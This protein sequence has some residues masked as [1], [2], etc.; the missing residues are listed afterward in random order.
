[1][2]SRDGEDAV[3]IVCIPGAGQ[4]PYA[5]AT[6]NNPPHPSF[7][8][9]HQTRHQTKRTRCDIQYEDGSHKL[10]WKTTATS[11]TDI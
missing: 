7:T 5:Y 8:P 2:Q 9:T 10:R 6:F 3:A 11:S 1:M 4:K